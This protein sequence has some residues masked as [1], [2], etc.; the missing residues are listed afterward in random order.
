MI[1]VLW[2]LSEGLGDETCSNHREGFRPKALRYVGK[3]FNGDAVDAGCTVI[4]VG[5]GAKGARNGIG[6]SVVIGGV[7]S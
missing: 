5:G 7:F 3:L 6:G 4:G 1:N 2:L